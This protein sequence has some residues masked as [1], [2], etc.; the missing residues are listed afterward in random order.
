MENRHWK[1]GPYH[2]TMGLRN[3]P[4]DQWIEVD[5]QYERYHRIRK[6]RIQTRREKG[7]RVLSDAHNPLVKAGYSALAAVELVH[8][9][10]EYL[11]RKYPKTFRVASRHTVATL[12][13]SPSA[14]E[15]C[16]TTGGGAVSLRSRRSASKLRAKRSSCH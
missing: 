14:G 2:T 7:I 8:E 6:H 1:A 11:T 5:N 4:W 13:R 12:L 15:G 16:R 3:M 10:A 9:V